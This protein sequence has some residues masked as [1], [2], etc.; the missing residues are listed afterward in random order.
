MKILDPSCSDKCDVVKSSKEL[1]TNT[2]YST[3]IK[4]NYDQQSHLLRAYGPKTKRKIT[5]RKKKSKRLKI[6]HLKTKLVYLAIYVDMKIQNIIN[7][8]KNYTHKSLCV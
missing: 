4:A 5:N 7:K 8:I 2:I 6:K 1:R 3:S